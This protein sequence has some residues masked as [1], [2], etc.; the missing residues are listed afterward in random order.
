MSAFSTFGVRVGRH[1]GI[2][3]AGSV[4][5]L[6]LTIVNLAVL[7]RFLVPAAFGRYALFLVF[8]ALLTMLYNLVSMRG[9]LK[10]VFGGAGDDDDDDDDDDE[11]VREGTSRRALGTAL[12]LTVLVAGVGML[13]IWPL[14]PWLAGLLVGDP[15]QSG[16]VMWA[17]AAGGFGA[18]WRLAGAVTRKERR[19]KAFIV[20]QMARPLLVLA[21]TVPLVAAGLDVEGAVL[22]LAGGSGL[23]M[24]AAL[25]LTRK[26]FQLA[27]SREDLGTI[28]RR[29]TPFVPYILSYW[30]IQNGG[31]FIL[32]R[33]V[34]AAEVGFYRVA[35]GVAAIA[36]YAVSAFLRASGPM[37]REPI[38]A[39]VKNERSDAAA[40]GV[41]AT[42]FCIATVGLMLV[43]AIAADLLI[44]VAPPAYEAAAPLIPLIAL[45]FILHGW[46]KIIRRTSKIQNSRNIYIGLVVLAGFIFVGAAFLLIPPLG[47]YGAALATSI[48]FAVAAGLLL[49]RSQRGPKPIAYSYK[50]VGAAIVIAAACYGA[51]R[52]LAAILPEPVASLAQVA[53][54]FAYLP[55]LVLAR[56]V[57]RAHLQPLRNIAV[58]TV[59]RRRRT[60][61]ANG[62]VKLK[63]LSADQRA[64]LE[65]L[66]RERRPVEDVAPVVGASD[67]AVTL[68]FV[69][70]LRRAGGVGKPSSDDARIGHYLLSLAP[71]AERDQLWKRM[72]S[73]GTDP[74]DTDALVLTLERVRGAPP[75]AWEIR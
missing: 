21:A 19:P 59:P 64:V 67:E 31:I 4:G 40:G 35:T 29:G 52:G 11:E 20:L 27:F 53:A 38:H 71:V 1:V 32:A 15:A 58:A 10:T 43:L 60:K 33:H 3:G 42:Y 22:G 50:R 49:L 12:I 14:A 47:T 66:V 70:A 2:Y 41:L 18:V 6:L 5:L 13:V 8:S 48:A 37:R 57:P 30:T 62:G 9:G 55:L 51:G 63:K 7:T 45:G 68:T 61:A 44:R 36:S 34:P 16:L 17:A 39:G 65:L 75:E 24:L 74:L 26:S 28:A 72:D 23:A 69:A 73:A 56:A 54:I 25:V 46:L